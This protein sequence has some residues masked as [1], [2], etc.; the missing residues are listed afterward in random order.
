MEATMLRRILSFLIISVMLAAS[1]AAQETKKTKVDL[2]LVLAADVSYSVNNDEFELQRGGYAAAM[3]DP[4]VL[5]AIRSGPRGR[6]AVAFVEWS[7]F[8]Q[9]KVVVEWMLVDGTDSAQRFKAQLAEMPRSFSG[10][11]AIGDAILFCVKLMVD[12]PYTAERLVIDVSGDGT[13]NA[14]SGM[15][16]AADVATSKDVVVNGLVILSQRPLPWNPEHTHPPGGLEAYYRRNVIVGPG[17][18]VM[19]AEG[20]KSFGES[21]VKKMIAEIASR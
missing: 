19:V 2:L 21:I 16:D 20:F 17:S 10:S 18:F 15:Q 9:Q 8:F 4:R 12:A 7:G 3:T 13:N 6:I 1:T 5:R 14:G 11:T